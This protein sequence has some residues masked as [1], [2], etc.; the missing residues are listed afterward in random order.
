MSLLFVVLTA[1]VLVLGISSYHNV[2]TDADRVLGILSENK[3]R[4][5]MENDKFGHPLPPDMSPEIPYESRYFSSVLNAETETVVYVETSRIIAINTTKALEFTKKALDGDA[6]GFIENFRYKKHTEGN[7]LRITFLDCGR[8]LDAMHGFIFN[9]ACVIFVGYLVV[10]LLVMFF[11][12]RIMQPI[13]ESYEKQKRFITDA[14]H[15]IKTPLT[16]IQADVD[17]L[18]MELG[19]NEWLDDIKRQAKRLAAL[20]NDLVYLARMEEA[21]TKLQMVEFSLSD[22]VKE[23]AASFQALAKAQGIH[24]SSQMQEMLSLKGNEQAIHQ[25]VTILL[26]NA[27]KYCSR[28]GNVSLSLERQGKQAKLS[29]YNTTEYAIPKENQEMLFERFYRNDPSRNSETGGYGIG[30]SIAKAIVEAHNGKIQVKAS[31]EN[32]LEMTVFL[33]M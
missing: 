18:E 32:S 4:F 16:I 24:F 22:A 17:V 23:A 14:G 6:S 31:D 19:E 26:D 11:S 1:I 10:F 9:S 5:P 3:G 12:Q 20:T 29:V 8:K 28:E 30:L 7:V 33:P 21:E 13:N 27:V 25:L 2:V 15:E